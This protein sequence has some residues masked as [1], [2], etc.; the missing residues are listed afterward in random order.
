VSGKV[1]RL[2]ELRTIVKQAQAEG[3]KIVFTNGCFDL[4]HSGHL[5]LLRQARTLGDMLVVAVNAD[6][7]V[8]A[9]KGPQRPVLSE[10]GR[11][12][13]IAALEMVD[14][15][16]VFD[17]LDPCTILKELKPD[18]LVKGGDWP[19]DK[20]V[21]RDLVE[22]D[23]GTVVVIPYLEGHSTTKIIERMQRN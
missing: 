8:R 18:V 2:D 3:K 12:E 21:G 11:A 5:H 22:Q 1:R 23:G 10:V 6:Q 7:S 19:V 17:E 20:V 15:V 9:L 16:I 14:Y 4:I 13:L